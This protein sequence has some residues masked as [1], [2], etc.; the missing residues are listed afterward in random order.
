MSM[1]IE[2]QFP[3]LTFTKNNLVDVIQFINDKNIVVLHT[4]KAC[5]VFYSTAISSEQPESTNMLENVRVIYLDCNLHAGLL[6]EGEWE[7]YIKDAIEN[8]K[9]LGR[10]SKLKKAIIEQSEVPNKEYIALGY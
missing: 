10:E 6:D 7:W 2:T 4:T 3:P 8:V 9:E 5:R 1:K